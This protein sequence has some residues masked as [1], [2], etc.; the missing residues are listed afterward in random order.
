MGDVAWWDP[1]EKTLRCVGCG[2]RG[3]DREGPAEAHSVAGRSA[4]READRRSQRREDRI[5]TAHPRIGG[6]L[7]AAFADPQSTRAWSEGA[8][9]ERKVGRQLDTMQADG[10][11]VLHDR[12]IPG[13]RSNIDHVVV[14]PSGVWVVDTKRYRGKVERR[15]I[16]GW[17]HRVDR[18]YVAG[19]DRT[20]LV[21][22]VLGA[23]GVVAKAVD[24]GPVRPALCFVDG[25]WGLFTRP[26]EINGVLIAWPKALVTAIERPGEFGERV[27]EM[28]DHLARAFP[29]A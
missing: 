22:Q 28:A 7:L 5:R 19:R 2:E 8:E 25:D 24:H 13:R 12:R 4:Q 21:E 6:L 23:S 29:P 18:L 16:G 27:P 20:V 10:V 9:G 15:D 26:F 11:I 3:D 14:A 17:L 1:D